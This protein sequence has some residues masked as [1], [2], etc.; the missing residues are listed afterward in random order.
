MLGRPYI[1]SERSASGTESGVAGPLEGLH[2]GSCAW[3][4]TASSFLPRRRNTF[5]TDGNFSVFINFKRKI[6]YS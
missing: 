5:S 1:R 2:E 3:G 6:N 4:F